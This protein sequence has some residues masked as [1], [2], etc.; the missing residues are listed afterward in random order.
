[1][2]QSGISESFEFEVE[3][4][5]RE[6]VLDLNLFPE[7]SPAGK[8]ISVIGICRDISNRKK[9]ELERMEIQKQLLHSQKMESIGLLAGGIAHD[10]NNL[11]AVVLGNLDYLDYFKMEDPEI[12][13][14]LAH[15]KDGVIRAANLT[16]QL[17]AYAGHSFYE[18]KE[19]DINSQLKYYQKKLQTL[20]PPE[21]HFRMN[22]CSETTLVK[23]DRNHLDQ[24]L[25]HLL[26][27]SSEAIGTNHGEIII[28]TGIKDYS[29]Q[30]L[31][32]TRIPYQPDPGRFVFIEVKDNG[33]GM[34]ETTLSKVFE[35]FFTTKFT[36][37]G[38]GMASVQGILIAHH[39]AILIKS[40]VSQGTTVTVLLP[41]LQSESSIITESP[42]TK[43]TTGSKVSQFTGTLIV[44]DDEEMVLEMNA[45]ILRK[46]GFEVLTAV[47]GLEAVR[48]FK[49]HQE[50]ITGVILDLAM[51]E[52]D[53]LTAAKL[54]R[55]IHSGI[56]IIII[57]GYD[58]SDEAFKSVAEI[59]DGF[60]QK[61]FNMQQLKETLTGVFDNSMTQ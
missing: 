40:A 26:T 30:E 37:R 34:D 58:P 29:F 61:P 4:L 42:I 19:L 52:M 36:G 23:G 18:L 59:T 47:N 6:R 54:I 35:P 14:H 7:F 48:L 12:L 50:K 51:P 5:D 21:I 56:K 9:A 41:H 24:V 17:M 39:G 33:C 11:L 43:T 22:L 38:L 57:S 13:K 44:A 2:F 32:K 16:K 31:I 28:T 25:I 45:V 46:L 60:V 8:I 55:E 20:I 3:L 15:A 10:F 1:V 53:G 27:N 49:I